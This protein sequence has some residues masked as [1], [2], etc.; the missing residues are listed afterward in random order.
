MY[1]FICGNIAARPFFGG[2]VLY[3]AGNYAGYLAIWLSG[4]LAIWL[5][6]RL[7]RSLGQ[8]HPIRFFPRSLSAVN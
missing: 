6:Q 2:L 1:D 7:L 4:Y 8:G 5:T 3:L